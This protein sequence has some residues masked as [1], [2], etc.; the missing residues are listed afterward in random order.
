MTNKELQQRAS[1]LISE[2]IHQQQPVD[3]EWAVQTI[4]SQYAT[5][6]ENEFFLYCAHQW[7][8]Q[9]VKKVIDKYDD[10]LDDPDQMLLGLESFQFLR[11]AYSVF[12]DNKIQLLH[13]ALITDEEFRARA[14]SYKTQSRTLS[15]HSDEILRF[16]EYRQ[17]N[18]NW[19]NSIPPQT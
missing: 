3:M 15:T 16:I 18:P 6:N 7:V 14:A 8:W 12:R 10:V 1:L 2:R 11:E 4:I 9:I 13:V 5:G 17:Q 19:A